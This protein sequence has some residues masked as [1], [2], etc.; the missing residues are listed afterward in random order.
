MI[1]RLLSSFFFFSFRYLS[2]YLFI[3]IGETLSVCRKHVHTGRPD[4]GIAKS[5]FKKFNTMSF[6]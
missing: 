1:K 3:K 4:I 5:I 2:V 6:Q